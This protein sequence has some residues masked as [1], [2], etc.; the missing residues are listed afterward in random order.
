MKLIII[1]L[2]SML[3]ST[4]SKRVDD[5]VSWIQWG[6]NAKSSLKICSITKMATFLLACLNNTHCFKYFPKTSYNQSR[7]LCNS[8]CIKNT[9][10]NNNGENLKFRLFY[11]MKKINIGKIQNNIILTYIHS[12]WTW[13]L[14]NTTFY[15]LWEPNMD[16]CESFAGRSSSS[17]KGLLHTAFFGTTWM[18]K[19]QLLFTDIST[20]ATITKKWGPM[21]T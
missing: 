20:D 18:P 9:A 14:Q 2:M 12:I 21:C 17:W 6:V 10:K 15:F 19:S 8:I 4:P 16:H 5:L 1:S 13:I 3:S 7:V 11:L